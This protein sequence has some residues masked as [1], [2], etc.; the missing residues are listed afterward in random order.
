MGVKGSSL[1]DAQ[2][3]LDELTKAVME[4]I[5]TVKFRIF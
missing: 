2:S 4:K 5:G 3:M 1:E